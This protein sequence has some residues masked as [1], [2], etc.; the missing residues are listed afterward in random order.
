MAESIHQDATPSRWPKRL[1]SAAMWLLIITMLALVASLVIA[2][3]G[4]G[5][6]Q[7]AL[8]IYVVS[9]LGAVLCVVIGL[10]AFFLN[11]RHGHGQIA[12][13]AALATLVGL[14][15]TANNYLWFGKASG[16]PSIHDITT[17]VED[18]PQFQ[19]IAPL[20]ADA[21][22]PVEYLGGEVTE[23]QLESYPDIKPIEAQVDTATAFAAAEQLARDL[24]WE[25][26]SSEPEA[27]RIE[28][29]DTT[30]FFAF[31]D[32]ISIRIRPTASGSVVDLRSKSR[33][34]LGDL[35]ANADRIRAFR[36]QFLMTI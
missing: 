16:V 34:G 12:T 17:D 4:P 9:V 23:K 14:A 18:P 7:T 24:G 8:L 13:I 31:K 20:R 3:T 36:D 19:A 28:A 33:V 11:R 27:G 22:N 15:L 30:Q 25:I 32:D 21:P 1:G 10:I 29:T 6:V 26:V 5:A 35:G 2:R